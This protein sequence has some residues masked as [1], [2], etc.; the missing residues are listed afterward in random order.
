[1][2]KVK[3]QWDEIPRDVLMEIIW[4]LTAKS[5]GKCQCVC[6]LW[7]L[8]FG[9]PEFEELFMSKSLDRPKYLFGFEATEHQN[10]FYTAPQLQEDD[11]SSSSIVVTP[12]SNNVDGYII[13]NQHVRGW[14]CIEELT[15]RFFA[16]CNPVTDVCITLPKITKSR[17]SMK[18]FL[19]Y[20]PI[21]RQFKVLC[22]I[23][24]CVY[25][26]KHY[27]LTLGGE[28]IVWRAVECCKHVR[29]LEMCGGDGICINGV[30]Y[31]MAEKD[32]IVC[33]DIRSEKLSF[34][35][36]PGSIGHQTILV[37]HKGQLGVLQSKTFS[38]GFYKKFVLRLLS[39]QDEWTNHIY[40]LR[41]RRWFYVVGLQTMLHI[42]GLM[43]T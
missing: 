34:I 30:L 33:F 5:V 17:S 1:M 22:T 26:A 32:Y 43:T 8:T 4:R 21:I 10:T 14:M 25:H 28:E 36:K 29:G 15:K 23:W 12:H 27:V 37:N 11:K 3:K 7:D 42:V 19:G 6:K 31:Y 13:I 20:D 41:I 40:R 18:M 39:K 16:V 24:S 35:N 2:E 9:C 38:D